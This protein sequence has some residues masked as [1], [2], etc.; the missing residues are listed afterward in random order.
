M[1]LSESFNVQKARAMHM[2]VNIDLFD[3]ASLSALI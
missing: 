2:H 1:K 3:S